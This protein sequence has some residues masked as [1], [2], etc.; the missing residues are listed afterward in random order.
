MHKDCEAEKP[1]NRTNL[2][3]K[4]SIMCIRPGK[5]KDY[6]SHQSGIETYLINQQAL[7]Q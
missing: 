7:K 4:P 1:I 2:E 6:Q 5:L 3:L